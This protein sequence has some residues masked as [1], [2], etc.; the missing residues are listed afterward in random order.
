[1]RRQFGLDQP[2]HVQLWLYLK[3]VVML[4]LGFSHRQRVM[5]AMA[6][7]LEPALLI[8]DEPTTA[9]DV[10]SQ[11]Q[12]L[13]LLREIQS[14]RGTGLLLITHDFGEVAEIADRAAVMQRGRIVEMG[15]TA[16]VFAAAGH[17]YTR[18]LLASIPGEAWTP[19]Q[20]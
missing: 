20:G 11:M 9:H 14:R 15:P 17:A 4:D 7:A 16:K 3:A 8:A 6:L 19:P 2:L 10:T 13:R 5:I 1:L 18:E 12:I